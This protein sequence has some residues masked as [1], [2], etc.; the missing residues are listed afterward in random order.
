MGSGA[1]HDEKVQLSMLVG[2]LNERFGTDFTPADQLFFDQ[3]IESAVEDSRV[4]EA[5]S[6]NTLENFMF[7]FEKMLEGI[8]IDRMEGNEEIFTKLMNN[9]KM[10][11][12]VSKRVGEDVYNRI[13]T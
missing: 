5:A 11:K 2:L 4:R 13:R 3:V 6:V 12:A 8:F 9:E 7:Y 1:V 10:M